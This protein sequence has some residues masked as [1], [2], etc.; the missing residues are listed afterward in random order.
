MPKVTN[1]AA[2][3]SSVGTTQADWGSLRSHCVSIMVSSPKDE[4]IASL[5]QRFGKLQKVR[6]SQSLFVVGDDAAHIYFRYSK[7]HPRNRT[8]FGLRQV[9]L[10]QL[11]GHN[12]FIC[13]LL[14]DGS[15][16]LF[17]P[18]EDF[19]E[20]FHNATAAADGQ[21]KVQLFSQNDA[22]QLYVARQ[23][24]FNVEGYVGLEILERSVDANRLRPA[25]DLSHSQVQT[26]LAGLGQ[27]KGYDIFVPAADR[28]KL[29]WSLTDQFS[30]LHDIPT[31]FE[32]IRNILS[33][34]DVVWV[35]NGRNTVE[36]LF[37]VEH[38]TT[39][40][41]GLLRFNDLLLTEP[42]LAR[43]SIVADDVRR[44]AFSRQVFRPTFRKSGLAELCSF[45]E[46]A[47]VVDWHARL[48]K[49]KS[50]S[51]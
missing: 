40:Y 37:E 16:P 26:L 45:L 20:V 23:G 8:F 29:D 15:Q 42:G 21:Y 19:E 10:R 43:F 33:E 22:R 50:K 3:G 41:S 2:E 31:G 7:L 38:S 48:S 25:H 30:L 27:I 39:I 9:D 46:Y 36:A 32:P 1:Q 17:I 12:S 11:E 5:R 24:R 28:Q 47:N 6:G 18:Y 13:F 35:K 34:V 51:V 4:V 49:W 14:N 44:S